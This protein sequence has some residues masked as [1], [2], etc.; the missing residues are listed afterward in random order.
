MSTS[1]VYGTSGL[2]NASTL[3]ALAVAEW[4][5]AQNALDLYGPNDNNARERV[6]ALGWIGTII[7]SWEGTGAGTQLGE[8]LALTDFFSRAVTDREPKHTQHLS[9]IH[10]S[11]PTRPY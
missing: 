1:D 9:L 8:E 2:F 4:N 11:E 5:S 6:A 10:I 3:A 7:A